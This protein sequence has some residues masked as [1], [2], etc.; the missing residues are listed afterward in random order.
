MKTSASSPPL[1]AWTISPCDEQ[2]RSNTSNAPHEDVSR[3]ELAQAPEFECS[4]RE[5]GHAGE[6]RRECEGD[7]RCRYDRLVVGAR[8]GDDS[9]NNVKE[10][11]RGGLGRGG[12][13]RREGRTTTSI[14]IE[15]FPPVSL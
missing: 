13:R 2:E 5:E 9:Y 15:P 3:E 11:L 14:I 8:G 1:R 4:E 7:H 6:D 10:G 12:R